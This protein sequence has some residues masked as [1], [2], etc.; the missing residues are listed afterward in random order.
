MRDFANAFAAMQVLAFRLPMLWAMAWSA[1]PARR[2]EAMRMI[3]EKQMAAA[4]G[5]NAAALEAFVQW[6]KLAGGQNISA[7]SAAR[8]VL[9]AATRPAAKRVK[10]NARRLAK[11]RRL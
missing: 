9:T 6:I 4:E 8:R 5:L 10:A 2:G 7:E 3:I 1:T 11:R